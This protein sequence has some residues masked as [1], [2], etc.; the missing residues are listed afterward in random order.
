MKAIQLA[1]FLLLAVIAGGISQVI[2]ELISGYRPQWSSL[3][4]SDSGWL[5]RFVAAGFLA[6]YTYF[7]EMPK[8]VFQICG[9]LCAEIFVHSLYGIR[10]IPEM[11]KHFG[12]DQVLFFYLVI[13]SIAGTLLILFAKAME[14]GFRHFKVAQQSARSSG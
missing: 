8:L 14:F 12:L 4:L 2:G 10:V 11:Y 3:K 6:S 13:P 9:T 5:I 1:L 7:C